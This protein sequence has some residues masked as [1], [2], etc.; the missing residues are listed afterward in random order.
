MKPAKNHQLSFSLEE[1]DANLV[2][3]SGNP[4]PRDDINVDNNS[5]APALTARYEFGRRFALAGMV[6]ELDV[7]SSGLDD[8]E[9]SWGVYGQYA[10]GLWPSAT[11]KSALWVGEGI[12]YYMSP[13]PAD[14]YIDEN[15]NIEAIE[16]A[17]GYVAIEQKWSP[18]LSSTF[19]F[20]R[21]QRSGVP[22]SLEAIERR[23]IDSIWA[24]I[25]FDV[26][27]RVSFGLEFIHAKSERFDG[28][29]S[30]ANRLNAMVMTQF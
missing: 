4:T 10:Q 22:D 18:R 2:N 26:I 30:D 24:N 7:E 3:A 28:R 12:G 1:H 8:S 21:V 17:S 16:H 5:S 6:R 13:S 25:F 15:G 23:R 20:A 27:P 14:G 29:D 11:F 9:L 19:A